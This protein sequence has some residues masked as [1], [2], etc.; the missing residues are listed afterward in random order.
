MKK[1]KFKLASKACQFEFVYKAKFDGDENKNEQEPKLT[2]SA[3]TN[4]TK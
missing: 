1:A 4:L 3:W 2:P